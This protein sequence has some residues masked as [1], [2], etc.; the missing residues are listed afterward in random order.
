MRAVAI[1][2]AGDLDVL[3]VIDRPVRQASGGEVRVAVKAAALNPTDIGVRQRGIGGIP[4]APAC[5]PP[6]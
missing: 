3:T 2:E 1:T 4:A 5:W 6:M